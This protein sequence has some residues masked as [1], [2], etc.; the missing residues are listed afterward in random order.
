MG[1]STTLVHG[2]DDFRWDASITPSIAQGVNWAVDS[3]EAFDA[4]AREPRHPFL[5][6]RHGNPNHTQVA[7]L[8]AE[9]EGAE[10][11]LM[12]AAGMGALTTA[13]LTVAKAGDHVIG[14]RSTYG[15]TTSMLSR[16]LPRFGVECTQVE[17][18]DVGAFEAALRPNTTLVLVETPSNPRLKVTDLAAVAELARAHGA[19]TMA[20]NTFATPVN[21]R[22]IDH[23]IDLVW[24]SGTKY[25]GGHG[26][27]M[28]G[29]VAGSE[30]WVDRIWQTAQITG[31][32]LAPFNAWLLLRGLRTLSLR[33][34]RHNANGMALARALS[35]HPAV[36]RVDYPGLPDHP[37]HE[38]AARQ[39][40]GF[41]GMVAIELAGGFE[42]ADAFIASLRLAKRA[43]SLGDV[44]SLVVHPAA[45]W[46]KNM[47]P[48]ELEEAGVPPGLV[49][50][51]TGIEEPSDLVDDALAALERVQRGG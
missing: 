20:D 41:G 19:L 45:L 39:M 15:G 14:Q 48:A 12:T 1:L 38:V 32:V 31:A 37:G 4:V 36:R 40:S 13:V 49:R 28:A 8:I 43:S 26:D 2:D 30:E 17:Q 47:T 29:V 34:E 35:G 51:S 7:A 18:D 50:F 22:P 5:Y 25:M 24:H 3:A 6:N 33:M 16:L 42:A 9:L 27:L 11:A 44:R 23:G 46:A 10:A 21:Q